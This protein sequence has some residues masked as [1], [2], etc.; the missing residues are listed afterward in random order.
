MKRVDIRLEGLAEK[1]RALFVN[2]LS[3]YCE[4]DGDKVK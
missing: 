1:R 3:A 2:K 4:L